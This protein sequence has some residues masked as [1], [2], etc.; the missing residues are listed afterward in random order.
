M[1]Q[2]TLMAVLAITLGM[3]VHTYNPRIGAG[4]RQEDHEFKVIL[5]HIMILRLD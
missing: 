1:D 5:S 2:L 3:I 4:W